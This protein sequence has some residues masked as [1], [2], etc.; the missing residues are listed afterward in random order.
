MKI[1]IKGSTFIIL[2]GIVNP[3]ALIHTDNL[4]PFSGNPGHILATTTASIQDNFTSHIPVEQAG[5]VYFYFEIMITVFCITNPFGNII[6][7]IT[8]C[9]PPSLFIFFFIYEG[10]NKISHRINCLAFGAYNLS[11]FYL[12][13]FK[14]GIFQF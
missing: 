4:C 8:P 10:R 3:F 1:I 12:I 13:V 2:H 5:I 9:G 11:C 6:P 7:F 14:F